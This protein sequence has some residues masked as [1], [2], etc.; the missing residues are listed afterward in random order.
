M[1]CKG[2]VESRFTRFV[3]KLAEDSGKLGVHFLTI[4][5]IKFVGSL[6][7]GNTHR[8][9][10]TNKK[11]G[12]GKEL[13]SVVDQ[14]VSRSLQLFGH[15][16]FIVGVR[17]LTASASQMTGSLRRNNKTLLATTGA[18][19]LTMSLED[20]MQRGSIVNRQDRGLHSW[21]TPPSNTLFDMHTLA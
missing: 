8:S 19:S 5:S 21:R 3:P 18:V 20:K 7:Y 17:L 10:S 6:A 15:Y 1:E 12:L 14:D 13:V 11:S 16:L 2:S 4:N 9:W